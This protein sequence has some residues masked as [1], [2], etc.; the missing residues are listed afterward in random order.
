MKVTVLQENLVKALVVGSRVVSGKPQMPI[1]SH[2][3]VR[4]SDQGLE[5]QAT[6]LDIGWKTLMGAK[7]EE[8][9]EITVPV[10][11]LLELVSNVGVGKLELAAEN[12]VLKIQGQGV[13][14]SL[15]GSLADEFPK[16]PEFEMEK[17]TVL[18]VASLKPA[19]SQAVFACALDESRPVLTAVLLS[20]KGKALEMVGTDGFRLSMIKCEGE[21]NLENKELII[22][23]K[24]LLEL[25]RLLEEEVKEVGFYVVEGGNQ[26]IFKIG[27]TELSTRIVSGN[28]PDVQKL[29]NLPSSGFTEVEMDKE[30]L[31]RAMKLSS[32]FARESANIVKLDIA[33]GRVLI[34]ANAP[35]VGDNEIVVD[36]KVTGDGGKIAFNYKYVLDYLNAA[37]GKEVKLIFSGSLAAGVW[38]EQGKGIV[39][40]FTH[41]IMPLRLDE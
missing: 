40:D 1:L 39:N 26:V 12:T 10:K 17:A 20:A 5:L 7:V 27:E 16:L 32:V 31:L 24:S 18:K 28:Y 14:A 33:A 4:G 11:T 38:K 6:N 8:I 23:A 35:Q 41:V 13:K 22:P 37:L 3:L 30:D 34:S 36:A 25:S 2:I 29:L 21:I 19:I 9:G 15:N